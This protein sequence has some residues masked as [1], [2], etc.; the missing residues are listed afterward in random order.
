MAS[1][2]ERIRT[3]QD[4][5]VGLRHDLHAHP[6]IGLE[7]PRTADTVARHLK[8]WGIEVHRGVGGH[9]VVGV[10]RQGNGPISIGLRA[11]MDAL[12][13]KE[14]TGLAYQSEVEGRMHACGHDG[15][16]TKGQ[17]AWISA[18]LNSPPTALTGQ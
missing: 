7:T 4:E 6:E 17:A 1:A 15:H 13:V 5:L 3:F 9:G 10:L 14:A 12:P 2:L 16:T 8:G 11:D 18:P